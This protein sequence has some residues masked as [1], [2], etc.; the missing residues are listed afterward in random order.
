VTS[1]EIT[2][3]KEP[4]AF[5][6][7]ASNTPT[8]YAL[9]TRIWTNFRSSGSSKGKFVTKGGFMR[10]IIA[11]ALVLTFALIG[12]GCDKAA[13][14]KK[15]DDISTELHAYVL[16]LANANNAAYEEKHLIGPVQH[17]AVN[18]ALDG[19]SKALGTAD[20]ALAAAKLIPAKDK[21]GTQAALDYVR[22]ILDGDVFNAFENVVE[23]VVSIP[24]P[25][26]AEIEAILASIRL[27]F[28]TITALFADLGKPLINW[29][30]EVRYV[31]N[32]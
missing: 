12:V 8:G 7:V 20:A 3:A 15:L 31:A 24:A 30:K 4:P 27:A 16:N 2:A 25:T 6:G 32:V 1:A 13:T 11:V 9:N 14:F 10:R 26:K 17:K 23:S 19:M 28:A 5:S 29:K 18:D 21:T 22:R